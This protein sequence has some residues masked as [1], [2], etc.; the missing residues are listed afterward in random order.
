VPPSSE[1]EVNTYL[2]CKTI[3]CANNP[4]DSIWIAETHVAQPGVVS[5]RAVVPDR[6]VDIPM[7]VINVNSQPATLKKG[8]LVAELHPAEKIEANSE[9]DRADNASLPPALEDLVNNVDPSILESVVRGL[10]E[11]LIEC[12][13]V[14]ST[15]PSEIG[16]TDLVVHSIDIGDAHHFV[17]RFVVTLSHT[18][19][20]S[21]NSCRSC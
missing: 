20:L 17:N 3:T 8:S 16:R 19:L 10:R 13:H 2:Q 9:P 7:R 11:L 14:L 15:N 1:M 21:M 5:A 12:R 18:R 4:S 6:I